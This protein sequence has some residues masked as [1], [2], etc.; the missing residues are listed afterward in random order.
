MKV[1]LL[2]LQ[3]PN[4]RNI[5]EYYLL[6]T[7]LSPAELETAIG[8]IVRKFYE[9]DFE[10]WSYDDIIDELERKGLVTGIDH[11]FIVVYA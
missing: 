2:K 11:E 1:I 9:D 6:K 7:S 4:D 8:E 10:D 5:Y 3:D